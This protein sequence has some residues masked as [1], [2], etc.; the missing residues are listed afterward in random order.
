MY[1]IVDVPPDEISAVEHKVNFNCTI[2]FAHIEPRNAS[3]GLK[4]L[5]GQLKVRA[6]EQSMTV[7]KVVGACAIEWHEK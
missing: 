7:R 5:Y 4:I 2:G 3:E 6:N 1:L